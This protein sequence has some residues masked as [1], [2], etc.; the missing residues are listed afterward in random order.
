MKTIGKPAQHERVQRRAQPR[1]APPGCGI[2][3]SFGAVRHFRCARAA[4]KMIYYP[5]WKISSSSDRGPQG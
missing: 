5:I 2:G 3:I 4:A 1:A